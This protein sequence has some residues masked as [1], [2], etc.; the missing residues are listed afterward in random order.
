MEMPDNR[1]L[2]MLG[3]ICTAQ[4]FSSAAGS[5]PGRLGRS[6]DAFAVH[7]TADKTLPSLRRRQATQFSRLAMCD[8]DG[9]DRTPSVASGVNSIGELLA[10]PTGDMFREI[11]RILS[12]PRISIPTFLA[13]TSFL[14]VGIA[15]VL[16]LI[17]FTTTD[18][19]ILD[20]RDSNDQSTKSILLFGEVLKDIEEGYVDK[21]DTETL[22]QTA[23]EAMTA[24]LDPYTEF[25]S[26]TES[27]DNM[28]RFNGRYG[29][30]G[31]GIGKP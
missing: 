1:M 5:A 17:F 19:R 16:I 12:Q 14:S 26:K 15:S 9:T 11:G 7:R 13:S 4:A 10:L 2:G 29:G 23:A 24:S 18:I 27:E 3:L 31:M 21:V 25:E 30:V 6:I 8:G 20:T 22:F 28:I